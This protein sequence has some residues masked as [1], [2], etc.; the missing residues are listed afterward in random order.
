VGVQVNNLQ[1]HQLHLLDQMIRTE[2]ANSLGF[3]TLVAR[4]WNLF[5]N[6]NALEFVAEVYVVHQV[7][8]PPPHQSPSSS[9]SSP[10]S[11]SSS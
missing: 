8:T 11:P 1:K 7:R 5:S 6:R 9:P 10:P 4:T 3:K 2:L